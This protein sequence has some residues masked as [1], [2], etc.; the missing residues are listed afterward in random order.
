MRAS[1][2]GLQA[3]ALL[4]PPLAVLAPK[5]IVP[6]VC[7]AALPELGR[8]WRDGLGAARV[9][10]ETVWVALFIACA[11]VSCLWAL[12]PPRAGTMLA[13]DAGLLAAGLLLLAAARDIRAA[14][15]PPIARALVWGVLLALVVLAIERFGAHALTRLV[16]Q[17]PVEAVPHGDHRLNRGATTLCL[18]LPLV[19]AH[20]LRAS[21][22]R[23][24]LGYLAVAAGIL[25]T[26]SLSAAI[27]LA[28]LTAIAPVLAARPRAARPATAAALVAAI[29]VLP[30]LPFESALAAAERLAAVPE[31]GAHR[32]HIW[33]FVAERVAERPWLGWGFEA[34][35]DMPNFGTDPFFPDSDRVIPSHPHNG[36]L[37][38]WLALGLPGALL[39]SALVAGL[40]WRL[41]GTDGRTTAV[42][43]ATLVAAFAVASLA[44]GLWQEQ[45]LA[46]LILAGVLIVAVRGGDDPGAPRA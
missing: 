30:W 5:G 39:A 36:V 17:V 1:Q 4:A 11:G 42:G 22:T 8:L 29:L 25:I 41:R 38:V 46:T 31:S 12:D 9:R 18:L 28:G 2:R 35:A 24:A 34:A 15:R 43:L 3:A 33:S 44:Y 10:G 13:R 40:V 27:A 20:L 7:L 16:L 26:P 23:A 32:L 14:E 45:W 19:V 21:V 6:L 37:Q